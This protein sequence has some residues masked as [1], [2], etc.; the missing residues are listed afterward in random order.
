MVLTFAEPGNDVNLF[1]YAFLCTTTGVRALRSASYGTK[2]LG[3]R[4]DV[5]GDLPIPLPDDAT[6]KRVADLIRRTVE[7]R[8]RYAAELRA[9]RAVVEDLPEMQEALAMCAERRGRCVLWDRELPTLS[10]W[11]YASTGGALGYLKRKWASRLGDFVGE[12]DIFYGGRFSRISCKPPY[13]INFLS[14]RDVFLIRPIPRRIVHPGVNDRFLFSPVGSL[15]MAGRGTF[16]EG[17]IFARP[18]LVTPDL[19]QYGLTEDLLRILVEPG[20]GSLLY[21]FFATTVGFRFLRSSAVGTKIMNLRMRLLLD[22]PLPELTANQTNQARRQ[23]ARA[24]EARCN[25]DSA[26]A[27]AIRIVEEEVL[28]SWLA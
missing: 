12:K 10:A 6:Q 7:C 24:I 22:L 18:I 4:K 5:L 16:G 20:I 13:G 11:T 26:E 19:A 15:V 8:E 28:P 3:I 25:A 14:Q 21:S 27:E 17:E 9:A 1:T 23:V 2:I